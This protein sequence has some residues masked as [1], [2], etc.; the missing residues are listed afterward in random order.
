MGCLDASLQ[1]E[2]NGPRVVLFHY[3]GQYFKPLNYDR[4]KNSVIKI[5]L[6]L[7]QEK[8]SKMSSK[9]YIKLCIL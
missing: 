6:A 2:S 7:A 8:L 1:G 9:W 3:H 4:R 5:Y